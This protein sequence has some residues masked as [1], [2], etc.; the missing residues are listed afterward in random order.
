MRKQ[1]LIAILSG[2]VIKSKRTQI[3]DDKRIPITFWSQNEN[4]TYYPLV[5]YLLKLR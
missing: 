1:G 2:E 3:S 4:V 5:C